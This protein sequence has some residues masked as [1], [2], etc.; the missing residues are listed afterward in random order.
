MRISH[1]QYTCFYFQP[2]PGL[3]L[4]SIY[5]FL[6]DNQLN[7]FLHLDVYLL[8][9]VSDEKLRDDVFPDYK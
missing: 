5:S 6:F 7:F 3:F 1:W 8:T 9:S 2:P 4:A